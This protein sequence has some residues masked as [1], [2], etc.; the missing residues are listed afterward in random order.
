[1]LKIDIHTHILPE[2]WPDLK[3]RY[4]YG[5]FIQLEHHGPGCARMLQDGKV[6]REIEADCWD[7]G[8]RIADCDR[9]GVNV[10]VLSTVPV[11]FSYW[12][13]PADT[14][15]LAKILNDHI[16]G[17]V[18][19][20][21][22]R[23]IGLGTL[24]MQDADLSIA[25][26]ERCHNTLGLAGIQIG[27]HIN[28]WNLDDE[29][30][31]PILEAAADLGAAVFVHPWEMLGRERMG[32]YWM[33]WLVGMPTETALSIC[34]LVF[35][36]VFDKLPNLRVAFAHG[37]GAFPGIIGRVEHGFNVRP[38]IV[39]TAISRNPREYLGQFF[40]DSLV[41]EPAMLKYMIDLFGSNRIALG[42]DYPFPLGEH[43]PGKMIEEMDLDDNTRSNLLADAALEWLALNR[44]EFE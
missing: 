30:V 33:P 36:G 6:F 22:K 41:H 7:A 19:D 32:L 11:M 14:A 39:A 20:Q 16:A 44:K 2:N 31:F 12:A 26:L 1:M 13:K 40:V 18:A 25:E 4:G 35:G 42:S 10:Q 3:E 5:G 28:G 8:V 9:T 37:G 15:D 24:P 38:E 21:P 29:R 34:S 43:H 23:F 27:T 17:L